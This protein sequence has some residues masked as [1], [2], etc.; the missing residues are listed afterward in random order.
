MSAKL[1]SGTSVKIAQIGG[2]G[3]E[4]EAD[5]FD[6][7]DK[8]INQNPPQSFVNILL[9]TLSSKPLNTM[10]FFRMMHQHIYK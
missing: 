5:V 7:T 10:T 6:K 2:G 1:I 9:L 8:Y 3:G 4:G